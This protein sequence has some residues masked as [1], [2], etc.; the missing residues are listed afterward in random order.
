MNESTLREIGRYLVDHW[1]LMP[2]AVVLVVAIAV[3]YHRI[4]EKLGA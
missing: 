1:Y 2:L 4:T 3:A